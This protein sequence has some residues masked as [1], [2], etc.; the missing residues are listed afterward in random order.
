MVDIKDDLRSN[1]GF[2]FLQT[3]SNGVKG[4]LKGSVAP[5]LTAVLPTVGCYVAGGLFG[6]HAGAVAMANAHG[7]MSI[8]NLFM[9]TATQI[10]SGMGPWTMLPQGILAQSLMWGGAAVGVAIL[11]PSIVNAY[12]NEKEFSRNFKNALREKASEKMDECLQS[13]ARYQELKKRFDLEEKKFEKEHQQEQAIRNEE[14]RE[15]A[16]GGWFKRFF[17][18]LFN[19][20]IAYQMKMDNHKYEEE[21][22]DRLK[23]FQ[24]EFIASLPENEQQK[25]V[26]DYQEK[27]KT[28]DK[29]KLKQDLKHRVKSKKGK[30]LKDLEEEAGLKDKSK[31]K[32]HSKSQTKQ[33]SI[34]EAV[35]SK[36]VEDK[37]LRIFDSDQLMAA[38]NKKDLKNKEKQ[39][40]ARV[41]QERNTEKS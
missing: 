25:I 34:Q 15:D 22:L 7:A 11:T 2:D 35:V 27:V 26:S 4:L 31:V 40:A 39:A 37:K 41:F 19:G 24:D 28:I 36:D 23:A 1:K 14:R 32:E 30:S 5:V 6:G 29:K 12:R 38:Q 17:K 9:G 13:N 20:S 8:D 33:S 10:F 16:S 3:V 21:R 18:K